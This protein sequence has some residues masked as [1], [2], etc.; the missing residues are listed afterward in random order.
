LGGEERNQGRQREG[1]HWVGEGTGK[2]KGDHD[3]VL[4]GNRK[5]AL[6]A[7]RMNRNMQPT[8]SILNG[9]Q[10]NKSLYFTVKCVR[11]Y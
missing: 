10:L 9:K 7:S 5:E 6:K 1:G 11:V 8:V 4:W 2:G 3:Q